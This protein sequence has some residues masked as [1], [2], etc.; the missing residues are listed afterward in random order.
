[1]KL[2]IP[3]VSTDF[4][5]DSLDKDSLQ[6]TDNYTLAGKTKKEAFGA[7]KIVGKLCWFFP[8]LFVLNQN[9]TSKYYSRRK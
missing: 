2:G 1:M 4:I 3:V 6:D 8:E 7:G 5:Y 9:I